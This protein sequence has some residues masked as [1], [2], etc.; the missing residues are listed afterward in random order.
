M[1]KKAS[2]AAAV[3][4]DPLSVGTRLTVQLQARDSVAT[5][6][7]AGVT[8]KSDWAYQVP[9]PT[10]TPTPNP[11]P[12]PNP[13]LTLTLPLTLTLTLTRPDHAARRRRDEHGLSHE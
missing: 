7:A 1:A 6:A 13:Y 2:A 3:N 12:N 11:N 4:L 5:L 9:T 10:P 8:A